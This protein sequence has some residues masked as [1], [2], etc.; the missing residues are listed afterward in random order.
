MKRSITM[1]FRL[2][3][4]VLL[5]MTV[6]PTLQLASAQ[7]EG[8]NNV[9]YPYLYTGA[10]VKV[11]TTFWWDSTNVPDSA[12]GLYYL[13]GGSN[14]WNAQAA[15][16][17]GESLM[18]IDWGD[19]MAQ[20]WPEGSKIRIE[21][22]LFASSAAMGG[23]EMISLGGANRLEVWAATGAEAWSTTPTVF[24]PAWITIAPSG[25]GDP[26][27]D[28]PFSAE[29]NASGKVIYGT[30]WDTAIDAYGEGFFDVTV[31]FPDLAYSEMLTMTIGTGRGGGGGGTGGNGGNGGNNGGGGGEP[32]DLDGD[33]LNQSEEETYGT[34]P[35]NPDTDGDGLLDGAEVYTYGTTPT[36]WDTD[37][38]TYSDG[39]EVTAGTDPL[40]PT[41]YPVAPVVDTDADGLTDD[42]EVALGT[43]PGKA[44]TDHDGLDDYSEVNGYGTDPTNADTDED[45]VK[46]GKEVNNG[47]NPNDPNDPG[48]PGNSGN[49]PKPPK[50]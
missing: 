37:D 17:A 31:T 22:V 29:V 24:T 5:A 16:Y 26:I 49:T 45:G 42:E 47:S 35:E 20:A 2:I 12:D 14:Y 9:S 11:D 50:D 46:D 43:N 8:Q 18:G 27:M 39:D 7:E 30:Q 33:G 19:N 40:D 44:D 15:P 34:D 41:S 21:A 32:P 25:G 1:F 13:Q 3:A 48:A 6:L 10:P 4:A 36:L 28:G 23:W 38:D